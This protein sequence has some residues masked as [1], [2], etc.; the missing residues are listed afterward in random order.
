MRWGRGK[1]AFL[2][3]CLLKAGFWLGQNSPCPYPLAQSRPARHAAELR[4]IVQKGVQTEREQELARAACAAVLI[5]SW[6]ARE[7]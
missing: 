6:K 3:A 1:K 2:I 7:W 5:E 4:Q